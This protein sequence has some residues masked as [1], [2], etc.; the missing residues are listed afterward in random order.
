MRHEGLHYQNKEMQGKPLKFFLVTKLARILK[1]NNLGT[2]LAIQWLRFEL[3]VQGAWVQSLVGE[4]RSCLPQ[5][6]AKIIIII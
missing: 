4:L 3:P 6:V 5:A 1:N 2:S